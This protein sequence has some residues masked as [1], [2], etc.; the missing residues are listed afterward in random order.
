[1]NASKAIPSASAVYLNIDISSAP[2][3][4]TTETLSRN[5]IRDPVIRVE[6][7]VKENAICW[8]QH[9]KES[10]TGITLTNCPTA[11]KVEKVRVKSK[12]SKRSDYLVDP[13]GEAGR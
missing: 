12:A 2:C 13:N 10:M 7:L 3:P 5:G 8:D 4:S 11:M 1:M 9:Q 6:N